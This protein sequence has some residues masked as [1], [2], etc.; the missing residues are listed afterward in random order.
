MG[1]S[2]TNTMFYLTIET[3]KKVLFQLLN[4]QITHLCL[5]SE[6]NN[7]IINTRLISEVIQSYGK[8]LKEHRH[9]SVCSLIDFYSHFTL[10]KISTLDIYKHYFQ[11]EFL[12]D[13]EQFYRLEPATFLMHNSLKEYLEKKLSQRLDG[14]IDRV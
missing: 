5:D 4:R 10:P 3:W 2:R 8:R 6:R 1:S 12:Q 11:M 13:I 14:E 9:H 7:E